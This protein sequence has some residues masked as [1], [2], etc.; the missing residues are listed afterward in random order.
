MPLFQLLA[1]TLF[2][3]AVACAQSPDA[4]RIP[5][6][7]DEAMLAT[8]EL[9]NAA[10]GQPA[11]HVS[12]EFYYA[13]PT[14]TIYRTFPVYHPDHEPEGYL[15]QLAQREPEVLSSAN[16]RELGGDPVALGEH[17][18]RWPTRLSPSTPESRAQFAALLE[19]VDYPMTADGVIPFFVYT[20]REKGVVEAGQQSCAMCHT[21]VMPDGSTILGA[22]GNIPFDHAFAQALKQQRDL[23][24]DSFAA[25]LF[26]MPAV[27]GATPPYPSGLDVDAFVDALMAIPH[28]VLA[29]HGSSPFAPVQ[30]PDLIGIERRRYLDRTGLARHR[31]IGDMMRYAALN[32]GLDRQAS[33][34][35]FVPATAAFESIPDD[36]LPADM[37][38]KEV[39]RKAARDPANMQRYTDAQLFAL[40]KFLY[41]LK[42]PKNPNAFDDAARRGQAIF[43]Q[44]DCAKCHPAPLYTSN[45]LTPADGFRVPAKLRERDDIRSRGVGTDPRLTLTTRRGTGFYK[46]PSLLGVWYRGP[47]SH[48]GSVA[49]LEDWF[50]PKRLD[51]DYLPTGWNPGGG[52]RP[53]RGH[54]YGLDL[55]AHERADL[56]AFLKTL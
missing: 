37:P 32:Q 13:I 35:D 40:A 1:A 5:R 24:V 42:P 55:D 31:D 41:S 26:G 19:T 23:P 27:D 7:W 34:R 25:P 11:K 45:Q 44:S 6:T 29:R 51:D 14:H 39:L 9:P 47:F 15:E 17:V 50:D 36:Q 28:G 21:R 2:V 30:I 16:E 10:T 3:A 56:I 49:T 48:D 33:W 4:A 12:A 38:P 53:V 43:E 20:V 52:T 22:Q 18:F 8:M 46:V 54:E